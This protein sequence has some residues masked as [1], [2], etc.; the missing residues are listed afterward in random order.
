MKIQKHKNKG[1]RGYIFSRE[2]NGNFIPQRVQNLVIKDFSIKKNIFFKLSSTEYKM[3]NS[4]H[5]LKALVKDINNIDGVIF[6][7]YEMLPLNNNLRLLLLKK[8]I[9]SKKKIFFALEEI[10]ISKENELKEL[11][12]LVAIKTKSMSLKELNSLKIKI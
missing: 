3:K 10:S 2:I 4:Y 1:F 6:Y 9:N 5:M 7:S 11:E 12:K 8:I